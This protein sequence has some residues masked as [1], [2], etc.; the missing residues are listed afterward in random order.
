MQRLA[1]C[2]ARQLTV[3]ASICQRQPIRQ[4]SLMDFFGNSQDWGVSAILVGRPY[5]IE[6]LRLKSSTDLHKLWWLLIK[7][8]NALMTLEEEHYRCG[9]AFPNPERLEKVEE[10]MENILLTVE[11]RNR[12]VNELERGHSPGP[13]V[14]EDVDQL[15]RPT[16]KVTREYAVPRHANPEFRHRDKPDQFFS[17]RNLALL[18]AERETKIRSQVHEEREARLAENEAAYQDML[19]KEDN[20]N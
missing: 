4:L 3:G 18:Q 15:F 19:F 2:L 20:Y 13:E 1:L 10:S 11:E 8:R 17:S 6:E 12:A 9:E 7:E 14:V 5:R 16:V